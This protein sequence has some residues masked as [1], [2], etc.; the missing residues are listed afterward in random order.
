MGETPELSQFSIMDTIDTIC[1]IATPLGKS[2]IGMIRVSGPEAKTILE[3]MASP[4]IELEHQRSR[5]VILKT[6]SGR[7]LDEVILTFF[8]GPNSYTGEDLV[9]IGTHGNPSIL[10]E[11][12]G[13]IVSRGTRRAEAGEFT[14]RALAN[15]KI[16]LQE[17]EALN[18]I[19]NS[20]SRRGVELGLKLKLD[21]IGFE[22]EKMSERLTHLSASI[23][24]LLD[25][26]ENETGQLELQT[27]LDEILEIQTLLDRWA[28]LFDSY[29]Y[30]LD[31]WTVVLM[32]PPNSGK[33]SLFNE[34]L[35]I[36]K[37]IVFDQPGTTRDFIEHSLQVNGQN[38]VLVDTAGMREETEDPIER[39]GIKRAIEALGRAN[40]VCWVSDQGEMPPE[41]LRTQ[42]GDRRW[43]LVSSKAD[44]ESPRLLG[45]IKVSTISGEGLQELKD[46][47]L[48]PSLPEES[49]ASPLSSQRQRD[50]VEKA[51][52]QLALAH[53][54][55]NDG[56][57][58]DLSADH[59][60]K[61][62]ESLSELIGEIAPQDVI[63]NIF[64]RFCIGK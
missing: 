58:F 12:L 14:R 27:L 39:L 59:I 28:T 42:F 2:A 22:I 7:R 30:L 8:E 60:R 52:R 45:S 37:S 56:E 55:L 49:E 26:D 13:E 10:Q 50:L 24:A 32:G 38:I 25:F 33:S 29:R 11:V 20:P 61:A 43:V 36:S 17:V 47:L 48:P 62:K 19:I 1:A 34:I 21:G 51:S 46:H 4:K 23:E 18:W 57:F 3:D 41:K 64:S 15:N 35:G 44:L 16:S 63:H 5:F 40:L 6:S 54:K 53:Q 31:S 9:E